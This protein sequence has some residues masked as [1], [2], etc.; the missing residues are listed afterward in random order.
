MLF[1]APQ[2]TVVGEGREGR[3]ERRT[4]RQARPAPRDV[5]LQDPT[6]FLC[7]LQRKTIPGPFVREGG[8]DRPRVSRRDPSGPDL[9]ES[10]RNSRGRDYMI[11]VPWSVPAFHFGHASVGPR[12]SDNG[13]DPLPPRAENE[14]GGTGCRDCSAQMAERQ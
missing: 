12:P 8:A 6:P 13:C 4:V 10:F 2:K 5:G 9:A 11:A 14:L 1:P 3:D 7:S